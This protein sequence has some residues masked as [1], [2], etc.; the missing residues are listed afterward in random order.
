MSRKRHTQKALRKNMNKLTTQSDTR[1]PQDEKWATSL[2][3][4][5]ALDIASRYRWDEKADLTF[6]A[7]QMNGQLAVNLFTSWLHNRYL[8]H[9]VSVGQAKA[10]IINKLGADGKQV[11]KM[12]KVWVTED[13]RPPD[14][15]YLP[16][17]KYL[18]RWE[19]HR[20][21]LRHTKYAGPFHNAWKRKNTKLKPVWMVAIE[22]HKSGAKHLHA[23]IKHRVF[24]D[25]LMRTAG[26]AS[27]HGER[28]NGQIRIEPP[29]DQ[30]DVRSYVTKH[31]ATKGGDIQL[32]PTFDRKSSA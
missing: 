3:G 25:T 22:E 11:W 14:D 10:T 7:P 16:E 8:D 6:S 13:P 20:K 21:M 32:S 17:R 19:Q 2:S 15:P 4:Q 24:Q 28:G 31:Y 9:A 12:Q 27:W 26:W 23:L 5:W 29:H 1:N 18:G 30:N